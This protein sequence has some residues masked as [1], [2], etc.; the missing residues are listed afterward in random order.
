MFPFIEKKIKM[1]DNSLL[2][3]INLN[4]L[5]FINYYLIKLYLN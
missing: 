1:I 2:N 3:L 5:F 4:K